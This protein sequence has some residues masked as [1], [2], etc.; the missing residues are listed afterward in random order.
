MNGDA[1]EPPETAAQHRERMAEQGTRDA[2]RRMAQRIGVDLEAE[3]EAGARGER[4]PEPAHHPNEP[5]HRVE[6]GPITP[7]F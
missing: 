4:I 1:W 5:T 2:I 6:A 3:F 7:P